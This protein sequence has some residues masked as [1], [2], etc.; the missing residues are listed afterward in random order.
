MLH[1]SFFF[2]NFAPAKLNTNNSMKHK[3]LLLL[4]LLGMATSPLLAETQEDLKGYCGRKIGSN[5]DSTNLQWSLDLSTH[6]LAITGV[7]PM[8]NYDNDNKAPWYNQRNEIYTVT[9][10]NG[11]TTVGDRS[12]YN[13]N[14]LATINWSNTVKTIGSY[15]FYYCYALTQLVLP[16]SV[17]SVGGYA[18]A[19]CSNLTSIKMG[20]NVKSIASYA[21]NNCA[22]IEE[23]DF[24]NSPASIGDRAFYTSSSLVTLKAKRITYIGSRAFN[25]CTSLVHLQLGDSLQT[26]GDYAFNNC[27]S[28]QAIHFPATLT[29]LYYNSFQ[30][31]YSLDTITI[32]PANTVYDCRDNCNALIHTSTNKVVLGCARSV[33]PAGIEIIGTEA[34]YQC[35]RLKSVTLPTGLKTIENR[36]FYGCSGLQSLELPEG[37]QTLG[38]S[39]FE[40]CS[41][42]TTVN[43]PNSVT[44]ISCGVFYGCN[45]LTSPVYNTTYFVYLP[46]SY[47]GV[48]SIPGTP[49]RIAC[50]AFDN[51]KGL[52]EVI[53]P[54]SVERV[55]SSA[56]KNCDSLQTAPLPDGLTVLG[57]SAFENCYALA[58]M[59]IP[60]GVTFIN[61]RTFYNCRK[62]PSLDIPDAV[63]GIGRYAFAYCQ[64]MQS[65]TLPA[66]LNSF[67]G[68]IFQGCSQL[69]DITWNVRSYSSISISSSSYDPLYSVR[70]RVTAFTFGDSVQVIPENLCYNM[71]QL[72]SLSLGCNIQTIGNN[73]FY[74]CRN[75]KSIHWNLRTC[76]DP[77]IYTQAPF[78]PLRDSITSFTFGDS[79][80]H[81]PNY[82]CHSMSRLRQLYIPANVSSIGTFAFRYINELD[83][84]SVHEDNNFYDSRNHCNAL[85]ETSSD[86]LMLGCYKTQIPN[87]I[88]GIGDCAFRNVR[89][90]HSVALQ[91]N[92]TFVGKE[93]FNGCRDL[94]SLSLA[95]AIET[96]DDYAFQDCDSLQM[97]TLPTDL[98]YIGL[99]AF[100][101]CKALEAINCQSA[102]PSSV[103]VTSFS[104]T[105]C[106]IYVPCAYIAAYRS[107]PVWSD[108]GNRLAG[109]A[110]YTL[111][112]RPNEYAFGVVSM[113][114]KPDCEH[115]A[116][117][118][119]TPSRGYEF[120]A[121]EDESGNE[122]STE[123]HYEFV[124]EEDLNV[125]GVFRKVGE[126][127][128]NVR[129]EGTAVW[130]D[131]MGH[132]VDE[133]THGVYIVVTESETRKVVIP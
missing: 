131:I 55:N 97:L 121:W 73:A 109:E 69:H 111:T 10:P 45:K 75:I 5:V 79:V 42:L 130:Y 99:R 48:Y 19:Y 118:E 133:P 117:I 46:T 17:T 113:I 64:S 108:F 100:A 1:I 74:G 62:L 88:T 125:I 13:L 126:G 44:S 90:L 122:L 83:S 8:K 2:S 31:C 119:A 38:E 20:D 98:S 115:T 68:D 76:K 22:K 41:N 92:V 85:I 91:D 27:R 35:S 128:E 110:L 87:D 25:G 18:F 127:F 95:D 4:A 9:F 70:G 34:F 63:T 59:I 124:L 6:T 50:R 53:I 66:N 107:A 61:E 32:N 84:I 81:I 51:C 3:L 116:I 112:I 101:N 96:I 21:F 47:K 106:P 93:A 89:N 14:N 129:A 120:I 71:T 78:Y 26:I 105:S 60:Q 72:S 123:A 7:G 11:M 15:A 94:K 43:L 40:G 49:E 30:L 65:I 67:G 54:S 132:R 23:I 77:Q 86:V 16:Q 37:L 24:G 102:T 39:A 103:D 12:M 28:L 52:K 56:F 29:S 80:R 82:L 104:G 57:T 114:Q 33:I 58:T 36:A